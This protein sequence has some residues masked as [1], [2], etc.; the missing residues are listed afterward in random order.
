M[1]KSLT[2]RIRNLNHEF[3]SLTNKRKEINTGENAEKIDKLLHK[4]QRWDSIANQVPLIVSRL[5]SLKDVHEESL[6]FGETIRKLTSHQEE[7][8]S[9]LGS[10]DVVLSKLEQA[11]QNNAK[12]IE[13]NVKSIDQRIQALQQNK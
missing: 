13:A 11:F 2:Q 12:I 10:Q 3:D 1:I 9:L 8:Q 7:I 6:L 5:Q 4:V